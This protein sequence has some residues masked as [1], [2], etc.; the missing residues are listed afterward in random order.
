[1]T[2]GSSQ[3]ERTAKTRDT[4]NLDSAVP[5]ARYEIVFGDWVPGHGKGLAV[6]LAENADGIVSGDNSTIVPS[7]WN[8]LCTAYNALDSSQQ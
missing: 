8:D 6:V 3:H 7:A 4:H 5:R 2:T 1:M